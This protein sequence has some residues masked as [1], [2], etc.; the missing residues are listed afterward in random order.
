M[1]N[2]LLRC[3]G[4]YWAVVWWAGGGATAGGGSAGGQLA[5]ARCAAPSPTSHDLP[6][7]GTRQTGP[8]T[9][10]KLSICCII[11]SLV[12]HV[13]NFE[14]K[15]SFEG[16]FFFFNFFFNERKIMALEEIFSQLGLNGEFWPWTVHLLSLS[17]PILTCVDP[18]LYSEYG[19]IKF[20]NTY[21]IWIRIPNTGHHNGPLSSHWAVYEVSLLLVCLNLASFS[22]LGLILAR[23]CAS[24]SPPLLTSQRPWT[25]TEWTSLTWGSRIRSGMSRR[26][27]TRRKSPYFRNLQV[28]A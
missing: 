3:P 28:G 25:V 6:R 22:T 2:Q 16:I 4:G 20:L 14:I 7:Q 18:D 15:K 5:R 8:D 9:N 10:L 26:V 12:T 23:N 21:S 13:F 1:I 17:Y 11:Y 24:H 27:S 19:S